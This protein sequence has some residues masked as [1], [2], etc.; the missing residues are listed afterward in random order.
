MCAKAGSGTRIAGAKE[1]I[2]LQ[3]HRGPTSD[4]MCS[5]L[6]PGKFTFFSLFRVVSSVALTP[7]FQSGEYC[8]FQLAF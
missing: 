7:I 2:S 6:L 1:T 3:A 4:L 5:R 8:S